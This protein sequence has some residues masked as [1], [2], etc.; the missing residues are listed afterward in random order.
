MYNTDVLIIGAGAVGVALARELSKYKLDILVCDKNDDV[1]GDASKS[2]S[3]LIST[4]ATMPVGTLECRLRTIAHSMVDNL[5]RDLDIPII[6]CGSIAPGLYPQQLEV[7]PSLLE[8]AFHMIMSF[9]PKRTFWR[10]S[11]HSI[12]ISWVEYTV[13][14]ITR[15]TSL[16]WLRHRQKMLR[17][18]EWN[19]CLTAR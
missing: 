18:T 4:S 12:R 9:Y 19:S 2:N 11:L 17:R 14:V 6:H 16:S 8:K 10:W 1:G 7:V 5:C 15:S 13:P 3:G